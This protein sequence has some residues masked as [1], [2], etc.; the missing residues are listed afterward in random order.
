[1][2]LA[3]PVEQWQPCYVFLTPDSY[4]LD[5][6][7]IV[8]SADNSITLDGKSL[9]EM[10]KAEPILGT[11]YVVYRTPIIDGVHVLESKEPVTLAVYGY[12]NAVS[13]G[14]PGGMGLKVVNQ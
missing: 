5:Y 7:K 10:T 1:M 14:Y 12:A 8:S 6:V 2:I 11:E 13:Y 9:E 4:V 3:V